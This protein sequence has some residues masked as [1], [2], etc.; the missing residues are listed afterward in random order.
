MMLLPL[1]MA[2]PGELGIRCWQGMQFRVEA[3]SDLVNWT[4]LATVTNVTGTLIFAD[5]AAVGLRQRYYRAVG[6]LG[7]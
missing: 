7:K 2:R 5:P 6:P 1:M 3:S 4:P